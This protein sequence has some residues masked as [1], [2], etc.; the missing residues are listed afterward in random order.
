M[1]TPQLVEKA[2]EVAE[3]RVAKLLKPYVAERNIET[4]YFRQVPNACKP[5]LQQAFYNPQVCAYT[6]HKEE[7]V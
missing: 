1:K 5:Y 4:D 3:R 6:P 7:H 2:K